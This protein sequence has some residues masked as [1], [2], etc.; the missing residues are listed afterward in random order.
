MLLDRWDYQ[1]IVYV[2]KDEINLWELDEFTA[3][4]FGRRCEDRKSLRETR[5]IRKK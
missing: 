2:N 1:D 5:T 4:K 3:E